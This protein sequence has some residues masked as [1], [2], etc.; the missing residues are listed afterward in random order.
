MGS[1]GGGAAGTTAGRGGPPR[2][3]GHGR[4]RRGSERTVE[5]CE[6]CPRGECDYGCVL[7][8]FSTRGKIPPS[9]P[10]V[11]FRSPAE[12]LLPAPYPYLEPVGLRTHSGGAAAFASTGSVCAGPSS[13]PL[14]RRRKPKRPPLELER[15]TAVPST[16]PSGATE[17]TLVQKPMALVEW[18]PSLD[19]EAVLLCEQPRPVPLAV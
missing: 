9:D 12:F 13:R 8:W 14:P 2:E 3:R 17:S 7:I 5:G 1:E 18:V 10:R 6:L 11:Y 15:A 16:G 19:P 4:E